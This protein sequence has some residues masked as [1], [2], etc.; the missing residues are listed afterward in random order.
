VGTKG[1]TGKSMHLWFKPCARDPE[2]V[3]KELHE[4]SEKT[5]TKTVDSSE[6]ER[7]QAKKK[8]TPADPGGLPGTGDATTSRGG[9]RCPGYGS[10]QTGCGMG[11]TICGGDYKKMGI[12]RNGTREGEGLQ[13]KIQ[14]ESD[15]M[16][17]HAACCTNSHGWGL[18]Q[19][20]DEIWKVRGR[21]GRGRVDRSG[22]EMG[23]FFRGEKG[24]ITKDQP[25]AIIRKP[26]ASKVEATKRRRR[27]AWAKS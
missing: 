14:D 3:G 15:R 12:G 21:A 1:T 22:K 27:G 8:R 10:D 13:K 11:T 23:E 4:V 17:F 19:Q 26:S 9:G 18:T 16:A 6:Q 2:S 5:D 7:V 20:R 25:L 24:R